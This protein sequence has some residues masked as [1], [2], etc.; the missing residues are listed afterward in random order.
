MFV[1]FWII[2]LADDMTSESVMQKHHKWR[3][4]QMIVVELVL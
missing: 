3:Q 4:L 1:R 2:A